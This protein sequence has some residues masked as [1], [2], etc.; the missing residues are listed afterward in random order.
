MP[1]SQNPKL[2]IRLDLLKPQSNPEKI[3]VKLIRWLLSSGRFIFIFVEAIVLIAFIGRFKLDADLATN[4][5]AIEQQIPYIE[6]LAPYE[7]LIRQTQFK[8]G[9]LNSFYATYAD[10]PQILKKIADQTPFGV[11][12]ISINLEKSVSQVTI[13]LNAQAQSNSDLATFLGGL[14]QDPLFQDVVITSIGFE[15]GSLN[16]SLSFIAKLVTLGE[17]SL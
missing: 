17:K 11:K 8:L 4:K 14:K 7:T 13:R 6:S 9:T 16:F 5:E 10:Y 3:F 15:K 2:T 12:I 1:K